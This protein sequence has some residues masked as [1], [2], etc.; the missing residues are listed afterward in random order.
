VTP[1]NSAVESLAVTVRAPDHFEV[2]A[3]GKGVVEGTFSYRIVAKRKG[4]VND[5]LAVAPPPPATSSA[6]TLP[7]GLDIQVKP[8]PPPPTLPPVP[9]VK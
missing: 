1:H 2:E 3:N 4:F 9:A 8:V 6:D 7:P 5:R